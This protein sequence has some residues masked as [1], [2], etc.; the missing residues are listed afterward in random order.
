MMKKIFAL[1]SLTLL[2]GTA[3]SCLNND[4]NQENKQSFT[5]SCYNKIY[6]D[7]EYKMTA[8]NYN[9]EFDF[10][11]GTASITT[12]DTELSAT[13]FKIVNVPLKMS[14]D[15]GY[16][17]TSALPN[18]T[19]AAG[20]ELPALKI[21]DF[22]GQY[23]GQSL[24]FSYTVNGST[25]VYASYIED[26]YSQHSS[27]VVAS[28]MGGDPFVW[29]DA[30]YKLALSTGK[31]D[32]KEFTATLTVDNVKFASQMPYAL[33]GMTLEGLKVT[34]TATGLQIKAESVVPKLK[35]VEK[36]EYTITDLVIDVFPTFNPSTLFTGEYASFKFTCMGLP[37]EA[38]AYVYNQNQ[39]QQ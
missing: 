2:L 15:K 25:Y 21:T 14:S 1:I 24:K 13:T 26:I 10:V 12:S 8:A 16:Y 19:N 39:Q 37:V 35:D 22:Y 6:A 28:P 34:P 27:T 32:A 31:V 38:N 5:A 11:A 7:G 30:S 36:P 3:S 33:T 29:E 17:F 18:V 23:T 20:V 4:G 9:V